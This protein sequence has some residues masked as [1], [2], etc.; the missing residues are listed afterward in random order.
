MTLVES[1][2]RDQ[3]FI[4]LFLAAAG[5]A[6]CISHCF[7][8]KYF[9]ACLAASLLTS[10]FLV[11]CAAAYILL[12][13]LPMAKLS[14]LGMVY[15]PAFVCALPL[16]LIAGLPSSCCGG[17]HLRRNRRTISVSGMSPTARGS[18]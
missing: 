6:S 8:R 17:G 7:L 10:F 12:S 5:L 4:L 15:V 13:H 18:F 3:V 1:L 9:L 2:D 16:S 11:A 14:W